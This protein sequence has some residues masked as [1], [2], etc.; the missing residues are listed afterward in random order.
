[1]NEICCRCK[2]N[3]AVIGL[4]L[5]VREEKF[6][7]CEECILLIMELLLKWLEIPRWDKILWNFEMELKK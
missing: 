2:K 1:M 6:W 3:K 7:V 5:P 4:A